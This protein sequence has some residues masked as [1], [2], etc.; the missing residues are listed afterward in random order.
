MI[1]SSRSED[2]VFIV[3]ERFLPRLQMSLCC[4]MSGAIAKVESL[5]KRING[6]GGHMVSIH[7]LGEDQGPNKSW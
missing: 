4:E 3:P 5:R 1:L 6:L 7:S 2:S